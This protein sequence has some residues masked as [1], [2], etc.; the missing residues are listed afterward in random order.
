MYFIGW[1]QAQYYLILP[2]D[3]MPVVKL[4]YF[5]IQAKGEII[6]LLLAAGNI[7]Y[8]DKRVSF[9]EWPAMKPT[10]TFGQM[11]MLYW[12][13]E[14]LAQ[15]MAMTRFVA[16]KVGL[17]GKSD[18]EFVQADMIACHYE[19]IWTKLPKMKFAKTQ[20]EREELAKDFLTEF[21]PKW[22]QPMENILE[23]RGNGWF[24]GSSA[25][26]ADLIIMC[27]LDFIQ[28][29]LEMSFKDMDNHAE[30]CKI[31][32][33]YPLLKANYQKTNALPFVAEW[34]NKRPAFAGF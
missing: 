21:L 10:T 32:D 15:S 4:V 16:R 25:T 20:E 30:R 19:D 18:M 1:L 11:P 28:E 9:E 33:S 6:R 3:K 24:A 14:E 26:Y 23:K 29:P 7:D 17:A 8:E 12:D 5:D 31:L 13:G 22:L 34:K 27:A 2:A